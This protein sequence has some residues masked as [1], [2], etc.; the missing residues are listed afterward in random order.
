MK[1]Y[2]KIGLVVSPIADVGVMESPVS[3]VD[4]GSVGLLRCNRC[5]VYINP[6]VTWHPSGAGYCCE[7]DFVVSM[8]VTI[9]SFVV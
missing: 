3:I 7:V 5:Q 8:L 1:I 4:L 6:H 2:N 9:F